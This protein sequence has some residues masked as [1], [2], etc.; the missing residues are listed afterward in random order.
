MEIIYRDITYGELDRRLFG[1]FQRRQ[2]VVDCWRREGGE[3]GIKP[4]PFTDDWSEADYR[5]LIDGLRKTVVGGG[6]VRGAF[7]G[8]KLKGFVS[9]GR[10]L[11]GSRGQYIDL[12]ELH[13][14]RDF[15][16][17]GIGTKLFGFAV[18][19]AKQIG[20]EKLYIS[21]HSAVESQSFYRSLGCKEAEEYSQAHVT[22]EPYDCQLER[23]V[24]D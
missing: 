16:R 2:E 10:R 11:F 20:A 7:I 14:S 4:D 13:V 22:K 1:D 23:S 3:W 5:E 24:C 21:A 12:Y 19:F 9:V 18:A 17:R 8:G 6:M 15:R